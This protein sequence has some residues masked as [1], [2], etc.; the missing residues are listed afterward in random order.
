[1][2]VKLKKNINYV[3]QDSFMNPL[4]INNVDNNPNQ[5]LTRK[6]QWK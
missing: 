1:M 3:I 5:L 2:R 6:A 4:V